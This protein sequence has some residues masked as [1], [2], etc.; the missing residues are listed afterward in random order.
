MKDIFNSYEFWTRF[1]GVV[2][3]ILT[4]VFTD[5]INLAIM[6]GVLFG[7]RELKNTITDSIKATK[8]NEITTTRN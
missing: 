8:G 2:A 4:Y 1:T 3:M 5:Q 7:A 6:A